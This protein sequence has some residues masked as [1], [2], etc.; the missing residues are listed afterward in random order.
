MLLASL[1]LFRFYPTFG[2][3][4]NGH[5]LEFLFLFFQEIR[6]Q[7]PPINLQTHHFPRP[8]TLATQLDIAYLFYETIRRL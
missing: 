1:N 5:S 7:S 8:P 4:K 3:L 6:K 2:A